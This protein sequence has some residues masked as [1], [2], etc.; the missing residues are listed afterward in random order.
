MAISLPLNINCIFSFFFHND[1]MFPI[2]ITCP[3]CLCRSG[4]LAGT[5]P[6]GLHLSIRTIDLS[7]IRHAGIR[8]NL[9]LKCLQRFFFLLKRENI[10]ELFVVWYICER[11]HKKERNIIS[12][13]TK[14][15]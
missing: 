9:Q 7:G 12:L 2:T 6:P 15:L 14:N 3:A 5:A 4:P 1:G 10:C 8:N 13:C 11:K